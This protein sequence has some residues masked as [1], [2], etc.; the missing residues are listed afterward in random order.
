MEQDH[1]VSLNSLRDPSQ[2]THEQQRLLFHGH[3]S[4]ISHSDVSGLPVFP[5]WSLLF[6]PLHKNGSRK[7]RCSSVGLG[8]TGG[9]EETLLHVSAGSQALR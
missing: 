3:Q 2:L 7:R 4:N 8:Q 6:Q 9:V 5:P 1:G